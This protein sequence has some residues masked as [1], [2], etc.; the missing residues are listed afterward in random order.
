MSIA[1]EK[2]IRVLESAMGQKLPT[3]TTN[4]VRTCLENA[5]NALKIYEST[6]YGSMT[7]IKN[8]TMDLISVIVP[9]LVAE[10]I[11]SVQP[12]KNQVGVINYIQYIYGSNKGA[13][14]AGDVFASALQENNT[15]MYYSSEEVRDEAVTFETSK[16][17]GNAAWLPVIPG[18][19]RINGI[20]DAGQNFTIIDAAKSQV[21]GMNFQNGVTS[22]DSISLVGDQTVESSTE[23]VVVDR[24]TGKPIKGLTATG[25]INYKSGAIDIT[26]AGANVV[27]EE[28]E[29]PLIDYR[30]NQRSVGSGAIGENTL[31]VPEIET[32]IVPV[33]VT[34][35]SRKLKALYSFDSLIVMQQEYG[36]D[37]RKLV[38]TQV[39]QEIIHEIDGEIMFDLYQQAGTTQEAWSAA[40]PVGVSKRDHYETLLFHFNQASNKIFGKTKRARGN[41]VI[42]GLNVASIIEMAIN[43]KPVAVSDGTVGPHVIGNLGQFM[44]IKNPY[45]G[46]NDYVVGYHGTSLL[47]AGYVYAP[48]LPVTT[49]GTVMLDDFVSRQGWVSIYAKKMLNPNL[50]VRGSI[51]M[52]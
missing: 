46:E 43:F 13:V 9:N 44:V 38:E 31:K 40:N 50:Y 10:K 35:R 6:D 12:I 27:L 30:Y 41:F 29:L 8:F 18:T 20:T 51:T 37:I 22:A 36:Q 7:G 32:R 19:L 34:A 2:R 23:F 21:M 11:V 33:P 39:A 48:Y 15:D 5:E 26:F 25:S 1:I 24:F 28:G 3:D 17:S 47:D 14:K 16:Y 52:K 49:T 42:C 45:Y 4:T